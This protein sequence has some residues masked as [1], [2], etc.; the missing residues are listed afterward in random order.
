M[1]IK[2]LFIQR[3]K[4]SLQR[5]SN[6]LH[7][8]SPHF[9]TMLGPIQKTTITR[10]V[11]ILAAVHRTYWEHNSDELAAIDPMSLVA[12]FQFLPP[13]ATQRASDHTMSAGDSTLGSSCDLGLGSLHPVAPKEVTA[14]RWST[15]SSLVS[16][17]VDPL[18][19]PAWNEE[20]EVRLPHSGASYN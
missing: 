19:V 9:L 3:S 13:T 5:R 6:F 16:S 18:A 4:L 1:L 10:F 11:H 7:H 2:M 14:D 20:S 15:T 8:F 12:N 17:P